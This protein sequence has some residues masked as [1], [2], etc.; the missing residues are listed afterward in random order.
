MKVFRHFLLT[1]VVLGASA[2]AVSAQRGDQP[3]NP[4]PKGNP[5]VVNP[6]PKR[7][8]PPPQRP[9]QRPQFA[10]VDLTYIDLKSEERVA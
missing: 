7:P 1:A 8:D 9:P 5:P 4:P 2:I 6:Q 10:F 3:G